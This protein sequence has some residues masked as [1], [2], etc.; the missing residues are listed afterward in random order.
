MSEPKTYSPERHEALKAAWNDWVESDRMMVDEDVLE[1]VPE[2]LAEI[3][4]L[5]REYVAL[6]D[7]MILRQTERDALAVRVAKLEAALHGAEAE[8]RS[9]CVVDARLAREY[10]DGWNDGVHRAADGMADYARAALAQLAS[11]DDDRASDRVPIVQGAPVTPEDLDTLAA[12]ERSASAGPWSLL[13]GGSAAIDTGIHDIDPQDGA[14]LIAL[15]NAAPDLI[16]LARRGLLA[17]KMA[18]ALNT[19]LGEERPGTNGHGR[20]NELCCRVCDARAALAGYE[21]LVGP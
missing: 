2:A 17:E 14:L 21:A 19:L 7:D 1:G 8:V 3:E 9:Y 4:R 20:P 11:V 10:E 15:R 18:E 16:A 12:L 13:P 6:S 5:D